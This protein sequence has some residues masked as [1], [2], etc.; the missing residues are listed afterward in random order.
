MGIF[1][2]TWATGKIEQVIQ[3]DCHDVAMFLNTKFGGS[4]TV[5]SLAD[6]GVKVEQAIEPSVFEQLTTGAEDAVERVETEFK[7]LEDE[8]EDFLISTFHVNVPKADSTQQTQLPLDTTDHLLASDANKDHLDSSI[9]QL[10]AGQTTQREL[11]EDP[12]ADTKPADPVV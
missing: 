1:N 4:T 6:N 8:A 12:A 10:Q 2:I 11:I 7:K 9:D 3:S 5:E